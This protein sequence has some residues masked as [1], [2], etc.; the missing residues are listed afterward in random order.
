MNPLGSISRSDQPL[1]HF[2]AVLL[3]K[4]LERVV[5][6]CVSYSSPSHLSWTQ[7]SWVLAQKATKLSLPRSAVTSK[8][9]T[10]IAQS[11]SFLTCWLHLTYLITP[12][13]L[14][15]FVYLAS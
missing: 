10:G 14:K 9:L 5:Y 2:S 11:S 1:L 3:Q 6:I 4:L 7:S 12:F 13:S 8:Q 15:H